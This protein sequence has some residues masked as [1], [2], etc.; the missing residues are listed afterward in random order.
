MYSKGSDLG[1]YTGL[2]NQDQGWLG[3][4]INIRALRTRLGFSGILIMR[5]NIMKSPLNPKP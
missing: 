5:L 2:Q 1:K 4:M 3:L